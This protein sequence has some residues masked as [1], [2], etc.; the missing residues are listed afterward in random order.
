MRISDWSSD[1]CSSDL[2]A[3]PERAVGVAQATP[4]EMHRRRGRHRYPSMVD[5]V[6][7]VEF[8]DMGIAAMAEKAA[9]AERHDDPETIL[10][11]QRGHRGGIELGV[12]VVTG[13]KKVERRQGGGAQ[14]RR[15]QA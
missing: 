13:Q 8:V 12:V 5:A 6:V 1:V 14:G 7:P 2:K 15:H 10:A 3:G 9:E 4:R 11:G